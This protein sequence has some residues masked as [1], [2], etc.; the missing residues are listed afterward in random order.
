M[1]KALFLSLQGEFLVKMLKYRLG[2][3]CT[4]PK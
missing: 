1:E 3:L 4:C 2:D